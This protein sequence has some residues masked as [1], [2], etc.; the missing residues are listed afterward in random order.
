MLGL[1]IALSVAKGVIDEIGGLLS[2]LARRSTYS[3]NLADSRAVVSDI[4][5][6]DLIRQSYY[7]TYSY[8]NK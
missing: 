6:Y 7:T 1:R 8:C 3:E 2:K 5:S 4:D